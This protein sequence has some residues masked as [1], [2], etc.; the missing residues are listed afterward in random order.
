MAGLP[1]TVVDNSSL[2]EIAELCA[3]IGVRYVDAGRNGGFAAGVN[4]ALADR[5]RPGADVLLLNPDARIEPDQI[6]ALHTALRADP[7]LASV[8]P[9]QHDASGKGARV[10]WPFPSPLHSWLEAIGLGR[11]STGPTYVIGA[12]LLL[13]AEALAQL[14]GLDERFFLYAEETDWSYRASRLGWHH[15]VVPGVVAEH[16]GA[17]T[18]TDPRRRE[19][20]FHA[21]QERYFR[22]HFG[23]VG[24]QTARLAVWLG[25]VARSAVLT[26]DRKLEARRRA[27]LY[28]L[29]PVRVEKRLTA[30]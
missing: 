23:A 6:T 13:R 1:V 15:A 10:E 18:S 27:A 20:H 25:A 21:S 29:G 5:L 28:R 11:F 14:G 17:G 16:E 26:G 9:E 30:R 4:I 2:P 24:W 7:R 19:A 8:A 22:K 12:V 3:E